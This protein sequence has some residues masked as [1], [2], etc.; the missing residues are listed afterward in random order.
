MTRLIINPDKC[1]GCRTC[2][3]VCSLYHSGRFN[4][5]ESRIT[6]LTFEA[7]G[8]HIPVVC[9]QCEDPICQAVCP[10]NAIYRD[11]DTRV[12]VIDAA[13]CIGC[14]LCILS[15]P[16]GGPSFNPVLQQTIKCDLCGG[17]PQ[18]VQF[19]PS[20]AIQ[21]TDGRERSAGEEKQIKMIAGGEKR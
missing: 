4:P 9:Q 20:E 10:M 12:L 6:I 15:C 11:E 13:R 3:M 18:C 7:E 5:L 19:C 17:A 21:Y 8:I 2:E 16:L 14:K 1:T